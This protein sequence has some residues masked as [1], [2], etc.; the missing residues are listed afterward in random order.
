MLY[1][2]L[3]GYT[4]AI[5]IAVH[6]RVPKEPRHGL[7]PAPPVPIEAQVATG[8]ERLFGGASWL[9]RAAARLPRWLRPNAAGSTGRRAPA[10]TLAIVM[11]GAL[12]AIVAIISSNAGATIL[13]FDQA[14]SATGAD[15]IPTRAGATVPQD[16]GDRVTGSSMAV[17]GGAFTYGNGGED[18][19][20]NVVVDYFSG[21]NVSLWT[22]QYGDLTNVMF[23][24]AGSNVMSLRLT[25]DPGFDVL[26]YAFDL[27]G[28]PLSDYT[29][30]EVTITSGGTT[31][32]SQSNVLV[33]GNATG[34]GHTSFDFTSPLMGP[35]LLIDIDFA[36]I[37]A[38]QQD[39]LGIDN[40][41]FGQN[42]PPGITPTRIPEPGSLALFG[43]GLAVLRRIGSRKRLRQSTR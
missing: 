24:S 2:F 10:R 29:I 14:R 40:I 13:V 5:Y 3:Q 4:D 23:A 7:F 38:G 21:N 31:L 20:P 26:L 17:P 6:L 42:P 34:P 33:E 16:Y 36:N 25:A 41:R 1:H 39:N 35:D 22:I 19:T 43:V 8:F 27:A 18:F 9:I 32:F 12:A 28:W 15:V 11:A 37:V 30:N